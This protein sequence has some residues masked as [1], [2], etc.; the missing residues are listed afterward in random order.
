MMW[1]LILVVLMGLSNFLVAEETDLKKILS[2]KN[3][4][5]IVMRHGEAMHN[6]DQL[7]TSSLSP[8]ISLT[9]SGIEQ[10]ESTAQSLKGIRIDHVFV[11]PVYRTLQTAQLLCQSLGISPTNI[12]VEPLLKEQYFGV[13]EGKTLQEYRQ[14]FSKSEDVFLG[15]AEGGE[16]GVSLHE[17]TM[18]CIESI[19]KRFNNQTILL[20]THG[21][22]SCHINYCLTGSYA[23]SLKPASTI[24]YSP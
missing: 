6:L 19:A 15:S 5:I 4:T 21:Y 12:E 1:R 16:S 18:L 22:N 8:G 17:R 24:T 14:I 10:I 7:M 9:K 13:C 3:I 11:S 20:I 2:E 23:S